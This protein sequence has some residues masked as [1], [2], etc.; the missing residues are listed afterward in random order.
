VKAGAQREHPPDLTRA[1]LGSNYA[2]ISH[3]DRGCAL[4]RF[5][6]VRL[7]AM[8]AKRRLFIPTDSVKN[9]QEAKVA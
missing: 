8:T 3:Q 2:A 9:D 5:A 6:R 4:T 1:A 7:E